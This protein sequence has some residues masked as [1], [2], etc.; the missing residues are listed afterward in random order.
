MLKQIL[1]LTPVYVTLFWSIT[2]N[3]DPQKFSTP[4]LFLGKF[5]IFAFLVYLSHF[6]FF[7]PLPT[8]YFYLDPIYQ[9]ATLLVYP[10]YYI[11]FRL[12]TLDQKFSLKK[13]GVYL[14]APT[15]LFLVYS[16]GFFVTNTFEI[17]AWIFDRNYN[18][19]SSGIYFLKIIYA[20]IRFT[21]VIQ[22]IITVIGNFLLIKKHGDKAMQYYSDMAD[23]MTTKVN[24]LN[25][26]MIITGV[27]S[28]VLAL[29]GRDY[30]KN[31]ITGIAIASV[32]F[33][34]MLYV[35]GW[36]GDK[37]KALNPIFELKDENLYQ[38]EELSL[39]AQNKILEKILILFVDK[40]V[41]LD[42]KLNI[43]D[44]ALKVGTNRT[45]ISSIINQRFN[46]NF[47]TF[48]NSYRVSELESVLLQNPEFNNQLLAESCGF[49]SVDSLKRA[50]LVKTELSLPEWRKST[51]R[52]YK[53]RKLDGFNA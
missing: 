13:H 6:A 10:M 7:S 41:F 49:G 4:R 44:I 42:S 20:L 18:S 47:C 33:S 46:Q 36:L 24:I 19:A 14:L 39:S 51:L 50:V 38:V 53:N 40:K 1:L 26:S 27:S 34:T 25:I 48:V 23:S 22:V 5:M 17:K 32:I 11:Y 35:I 2:L 9:Y 43:Q 52:L 29:L 15:I 3:T 12:L 30:F 45:Y 37:Q 28:L 31:E 8:L 21:A 16:I